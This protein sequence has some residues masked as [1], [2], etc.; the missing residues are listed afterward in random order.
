MINEWDFDDDDASLARGDNFP[1][2]LTGGPWSGDDGEVI[3]LTGDPTTLHPETSAFISA[4]GGLFG[5]GC[6]GELDDLNIFGGT[7]AVAT[8]TIQDAVNAATLQQGGP[9]L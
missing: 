7:A 5:D 3:L 6:D 8:S 2:S 9:C 1:D 4:W